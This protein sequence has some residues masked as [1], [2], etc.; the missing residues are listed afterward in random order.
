MIKKSTFSEIIIIFSLIIGILS[1]VKTSLNPIYRLGG[2]ILS[3]TLISLYIILYIQESIRK[4]TEIQIK[5]MLYPI[6]SKLDKIEGW[7]EAIDHFLPNKKGQMHPVTL[8]II[9]IIIIITILYLQGK[10]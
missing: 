1:Y 5:K 9:I 7:K 8:L 2:L 6:K 4:Q 10:L 3:I